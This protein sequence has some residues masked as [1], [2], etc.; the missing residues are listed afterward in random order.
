MQYKVVH[1]VLK[2]S[3]WVNNHVSIVSGLY[4]NINQSTLH[5]VAYIIKTSFHK[6]WIQ[7]ENNI[8]LTFDLF[9]DAFGD[10]EPML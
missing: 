7:Q 3:F 9:F 8:L 10:I 2:Q 4:H 6:K 5:N 1:K